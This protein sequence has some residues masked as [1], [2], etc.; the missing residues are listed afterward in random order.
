MG[1]LFHF[2]VEASSEEVT[3]E[4]AKLLA[5]ALQVFARL[6]YTRASLKEIAV[7]ADMTAA[8]VNYY[9][10]TKQQLFV[11]VIDEAF[12]RLQALIAARTAPH[13]DFEARALGLIEAHHVFAT[14][15]RDEAEL[16]VR[17]AFRPPDASL[18]PLLERYA[19]V[20]TL[21]REIFRDGVRHRHLKL[22]SGLS[23]D[24]AAEHMLGQLEL[25]LIQRLHERRLPRA[26]VPHFSVEEVLALALDG[27]SRG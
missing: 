14:T 15:L 22:R 3:P 26:Q 9:F 23:A 27:V 1:L 13:L 11:A 18:D 16:I 19:P 6:D 4:R 5:S 25:M 24:R 7:K 10:G 12:R 8:M 17:A 20:R 2:Q 21:A